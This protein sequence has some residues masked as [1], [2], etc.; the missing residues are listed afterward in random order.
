MSSVKG[1]RNFQFVMRDVR[2]FADENRFSIKPL[3]FLVGENSTGKSTV[4]GCLQTL[5]DSSPNALHVHRPID[6]NVP[7]YQMG[8]FANI[9][10]KSRPPK[11]K[12]ELGIEYEAGDATF[13]TRLTFAEKKQGS[14]PVV[15]RA[16]V[17]FK[18]TSIIFEHEPG[19]KTRY[20]ITGDKETFTVHIGDP[21]RGALSRSVA[22]FLPD[23]FNLVARPGAVKSEALNS[24]AQSNLAAV[25]NA[26]KEGGEVPFFMDRMPLPCEV[27][28]I[29]PIRSR[30]RRTYDP[31]GDD[32]TPD[33]GEIPMALMNLFM[34]SDKEW[35]GLKGGLVK[36][37]KAS[38]L[39]DDIV[40][41]KLGRAKSDPFQLQFGIRC[42][43]GFNL[44]DVGYGVS[45]L[46]STLVRVLHKKQAFCFLLQQP[47]VHLHPR[48]QAELSSLLVDMTQGERGH[49][50]IV[51][52]HS[53]YMVDRARIEIMNGNI[54]PEDVSLIYFDPVDKHRVQPHSIGFDSEANMKGEPDNFREFFLR[55]G[56]RL[57]GFDLDET[58][59][60]A[61]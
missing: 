17:T 43:A 31:Q 26:W 51:E 57:L 28:S 29:A 10:H 5:A 4:L 21:W 61:A 45:Q 41:K 23:W 49:S 54:A 34:A 2:C 38:G 37:G 18:G 55:E 11:D 35:E 50:F 32:P 44:I 48:V 14:E 46:L 22:D 3:T 33:G 27:A 42:S 6:F 59:R 36:F 25:V 15:A 58:E 56:H 16:V 9:V 39:F 13:S 60:S 7:P 1:R 8:A 20:R 24:S 30:P 47:E 40:V 19:L 53:D 52:T 12:F